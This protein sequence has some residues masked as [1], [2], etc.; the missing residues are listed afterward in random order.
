MT[1]ARGWPWIAAL[2]V[3]VAMTAAQA[4]APRPAAP[5]DC[6]TRPEAERP[7]CEQEAKIAAACEGMSGDKLAACRDAVRN[8]REKRDCRR[9]P[10]GY[11]RN[12][13]ED[14]NLR[15]EIA[16]RCGTNTGE[17]FDRCYGEVMARALHP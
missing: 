9:L 16:A 8:T 17:D 1:A 11:G 4:A 7:Q 15:D 13:C 3:T 10:E 14:Q 2:A 5:T 6:S 12:K